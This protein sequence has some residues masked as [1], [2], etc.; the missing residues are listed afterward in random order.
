[1]SGC[2]KKQGAS[3]RECLSIFHIWDP[4]YIQNLACNQDLA[5]VSWPTS[6][7]YARSL[8][9]GTGVCLIQGFYL[10]FYGNCI[11]TVVAVYWCHCI[12]MGCITDSFVT[13]SAFVFQL[14]KFWQLVHFDFCVAIFIRN[15]GLMSFSI[16]NGTIRNEKSVLS[17]TMVH[18]M[19]MVNLTLDMHLTR[20]VR[21]VIISIGYVVFILQFHL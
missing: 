20:F 2:A 7:L 13:N 4:A 12:T 19:L 3:P 11:H 17:C 21:C 1:M 16:G 8:N 5:S 9:S 15:A 10:K 6:Y 18:H 14:Q